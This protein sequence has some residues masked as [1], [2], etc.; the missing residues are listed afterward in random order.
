MVST[1]PF[2]R[3]FTRDPMLLDGR[4]DLERRRQ[5]LFRLFSSFGQVYVVDGGVLVDGTAS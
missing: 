3:Q 4:L 5:E 1:S 2:A